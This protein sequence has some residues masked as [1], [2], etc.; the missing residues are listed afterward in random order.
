MVAACK[1]EQVSKVRAR[2]QAN[3]A[4]YYATQCLT[5][6][7]QRQ[8]I[9]KKMALIATPRPEAFDEDLPRQYQEAF[10]LEL[11]HQKL[12]EREG[13]DKDFWERYDRYMESPEWKEKR[14]LVLMRAAYLCEGCGMKK[15]V[16][17]H[18]LTYEHFE[19]EFLWEL[20]AVCLDCHERVHGK[21]IGN[22]G[23]FK[24]P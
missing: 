3:G 21:V 19:H 24:R 13:Q 17:V 6:G 10:R 5:C 22:N 12:V 20:R 15:A 18:H 14:R 8:V 7:A 4:M 23:R 1:H 9:P 2:T 16:H 11:A